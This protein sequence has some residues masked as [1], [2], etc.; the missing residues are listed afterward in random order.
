MSTAFIADKCGCGNYKRKAK[1][2]CLVCERK[3]LAAYGVQPEKLQAK[4]K[5]EN[6]AVDVAQANIAA[7][8]YK[9][10]FPQIETFVKARR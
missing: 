1:T 8:Q 4:L 9:K 3:S 7:A 10:A 5:E 2:E 6:I